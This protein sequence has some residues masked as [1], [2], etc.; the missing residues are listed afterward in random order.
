MNTIL[1]IAI[2]MI[3]LDFIYL[4]ISYDIMSKQ[5]FNIQN[6]K[7]SIRIVPVILCYIVMV[8]GLYHF[9][10]KDKRPVKEALLLGLLVYSVY[11]LTN[12]S[13]FNNWTTKVVLLD[14]VWG[15]FLFGIVT[16]MVYRLTNKQIDFSEV[17]PAS[18][19]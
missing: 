10:I 13:I 3:V 14:I 19:S 4:N 2:I 15:T 8:L 7:L 17:H 16:Y 1:L 6:Q 9:I 18:I 5:I 11:E 12:I